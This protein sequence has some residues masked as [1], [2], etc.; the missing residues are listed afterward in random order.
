[1]RQTLYE[2][3]AAIPLLTFA[4]IPLEWTFAEKQNLPSGEDRSEIEREGQ[5]VGRDRVANWGLAHQKSVKRMDIIGRCLGEMVIRKGRVELSAFA[6]DA[7]AHGALE[8]R[9]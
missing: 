1:M 5:F 8:R 4:V 2:I 9:L 6:I 3:P 7:L